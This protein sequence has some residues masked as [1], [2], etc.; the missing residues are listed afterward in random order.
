MARL[1]WETITLHLRNPFRLA[2]GVTDTRQ[3]FWIR[4][5]ND[6]GWGEGTIPPYYRVDPTAMTACWQTAAGKG[7]PFPDDVESIPGWIPAGPAPSRSALDLALHDRI[8]KRRGV[9]LYQLLK[10]PKPPNLAT[11]FTIAIDTPEAMAK[12]AREIPDYKIIKL[13]LGSEDDESRVRAVREARPDAT[14]YV[15]A[16]SGWTFDDA[17]KHLKWLEKYNLELIEQPLGV[18]QHAAMGELQKRT[19]LP[20]VAD[21]S[22]Q[23]LEDIEKL[24][25]AGVRGINL[26]LMKVGGISP[27]LKILKRARDFGMKVM[28]GCMMETSVGLTAMTHLAGLGDWLDLDAPLLIKD[29][30]FE[31]VRYDS[32][33]RITVPERPGIGAIRK[34]NA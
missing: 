20:I 34:A 31:G 2:H 21:E 27:A 19:S 29:D 25:K 5:E 6:E 11:A 15:D 32:S 28:L 9:P 13:K 4:L 24:G 10:L 23:S 17:V 30:P 12:M 1:S 26:K 8:A 14:L 22:V 33:A 3:A 18:D 16:N 7:E